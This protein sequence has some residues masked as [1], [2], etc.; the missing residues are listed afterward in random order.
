MK[1]ERISDC[2]LWMMDWI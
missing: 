2:D 1:R